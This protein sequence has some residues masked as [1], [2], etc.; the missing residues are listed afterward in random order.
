MRQRLLGPPGATSLPLSSAKAPLAPETVHILE[1]R[2]FIIFLWSMAEF[3]EEVAAC[4]IFIYDVIFRIQCSQILAGLNL[5]KR[6]LLEY[7][8]IHSV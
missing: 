8:V 4:K 2:N 6:R 1:R 5:W 7:V 3:K